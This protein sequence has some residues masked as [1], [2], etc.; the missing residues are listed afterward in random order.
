MQVITKLH[1]KT[2]EVMLFLSM[3]KLNCNLTGWWSRPTCEVVILFS[4]SK[5]QQPCHGRV[6]ML[7]SLE[8]WPS[9]VL[10]HSVV[11]QNLRASFGEQSG[12]DNSNSFWS[13]VI[14]AITGSYPRPSSK[15]CCPSAEC[16]PTAALELRSTY[17]HTFMQTCT[18]DTHDTCIVKCP[19]C[20]Q[21]SHIADSEESVM[22]MLGRCLPHIVPNVLLAKREVKPVLLPLLLLFFY[23]FHYCHNHGL[24]L[25]LDN[26]Y[27]QQLG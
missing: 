19:S 26:R 20:F 21:V 5:I 13:L 6:T 27:T 7:S 1:L 18:Y 8:G 4:F 23:P 17:T 24:V 11:R 15:P 9:S 2:F 22:L 12:A 25:W 16:A 10:R 14:F 3:L